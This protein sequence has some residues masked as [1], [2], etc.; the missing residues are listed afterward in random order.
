MLRGLNY[1]GAVRFVLHQ[2]H[3]RVRPVRQQLAHLEEGCWEVPAAA[4]PIQQERISAAGGLQDV[5]DLLI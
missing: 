4:D 2:L 3:H 5:D 1:G